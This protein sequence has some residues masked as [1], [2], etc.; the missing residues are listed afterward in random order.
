M[1]G[2]WLVGGWAWVWE[3]GWGVLFDPAFVFV[4]AESEVSTIGSSANPKTPFSNDGTI[5]RCDNDASPLAS[6]FS[7]ANGLL[8]TFV[9]AVELPSA[10]LHRIRDDRRTKNESSTTRCTLPQSTTATHC[11]TATAARPLRQGHCGAGA[12]CDA[13]LLRDVSLRID[14]TSSATN[15]LQPRETHKRYANVRVKKQY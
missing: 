14:S 8:D 6:I 3:W 13:M 4:G 7:L 11:G 15:Q 5:G 1:G 2:C 9:A 12:W 10:G